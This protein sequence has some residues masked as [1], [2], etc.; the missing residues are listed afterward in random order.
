ME[1]FANILAVLLLLVVDCYVIYSH[2]VASLSSR[3][4][5]WIGQK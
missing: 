4:R 3:I 1:A 5:L 2:I